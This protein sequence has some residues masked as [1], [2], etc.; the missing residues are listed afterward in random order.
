MGACLLT[1]WK[2]NLPEMFEPDVEIMTYRS[3]DECA[4]KTNYLLAHQDE[5]AAIAAAGQCRTLRD[6]T[7]LNR[8]EQLAEILRE[9]ISGKM[10]LV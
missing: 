6:H 7:Y 2:V 4:E 9:L 3:A 8:S 1:D 10:C 5:L